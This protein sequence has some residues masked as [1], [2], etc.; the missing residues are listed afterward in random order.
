MLM[1]QMAEETSR[2]TFPRNVTSI[3]WVKNKPSNNTA[4][5]D[6]KHLVSCLAYAS[7]L[8]MEATCSAET[9]A[10]IQRIARRHIF[11]T[12]AVRTPKHA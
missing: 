9:S 12:T 5:R 11:V 8:K 4:Y 2:P 6:G 3:C 1:K 10:D 7:T